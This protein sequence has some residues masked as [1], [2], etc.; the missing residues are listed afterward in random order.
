MWHCPY[1]FAYNYYAVR[2]KGN[3][4]IKTFSEEDKDEA[5]K[6]AKE[7]DKVTKEHY[8]GCPRHIKS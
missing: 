8:A 3:N 1:K 6:M 4:I 5:F 7:T 2:D